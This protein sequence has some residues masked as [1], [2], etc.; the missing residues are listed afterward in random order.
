MSVLFVVLPVALLLGAFFVFLFV[1]VVRTGQL[2]D[3]ESPALDAV[4]DRGRQRRTKNEEAQ[5]A[6]APLENDRTVNGAEIGA[7]QVAAHTAMQKTQP[8]PN[9]DNGV[10]VFCGAKSGVEPRFVEEASWLGRTLADLGLVTIYGAGGV[11]M[12]GALADAVIKA[13]GEIVGVIPDCLVKR[14]FCRN[15][16][17]E[18]IITNDMESRKIAM[19]ERS[20][21]FIVLPG[22]LGTLDEAFE[23]AT[24]TQLGLHQKSVIFYDENGYFD[25]LEMMLEKACEAGFLTTNDRKIIQFFKNRE[26]MAA[27]L[28]NFDTGLRI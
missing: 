5:L 13:G 9:R 10:A 24:Y 12:M 11:G 16:L 2:D 27:F 15:G 3:L 21:V 19:R 17:S 6:L 25:A 1:W 22:G 14:E 28:A 7:V 20:Q 18:T 8:S 26:A 23:M 4:F